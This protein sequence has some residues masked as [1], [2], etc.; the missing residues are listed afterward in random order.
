MLRIV[1]APF[2]ALFFVS[3]GLLGIAGKYPVTQET[4]FMNAPNPLSLASLLASGALA[5][6]YH[7]GLKR[8]VKQPHT[9]NER[10]TIYTLDFVVILAL[11]IAVPSFVVI[12]NGALD[13]S[14]PKSVAVE[15]VDKK[16]VYGRYGG[17]FVYLRDLSNSEHIIRIRVD[18]SKYQASDIGDFAQVVTKEGFLGYEWLMD[19][20]LYKTSP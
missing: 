7:L 1:V 6:L 12:V 13:S 8:Q 19:Y 10:G 4:F 16:I 17:R 18:G 5:M 2:I 20:S 3:L 14:T 11:L 9:I 15:I